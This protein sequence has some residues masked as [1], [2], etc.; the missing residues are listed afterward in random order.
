MLQAS[1][2]GPRAARPS[3]ILTSGRVLRAVNAGTAP[4][5]WRGDHNKSLPYALA[6]GEHQRNRKRSAPAFIAGLVAARGVEP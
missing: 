3:A 6:I 4:S 1:V 5:V 2:S